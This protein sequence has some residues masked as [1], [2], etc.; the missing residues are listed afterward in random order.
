MQQ[1]R[2]CGFIIGKSVRHSSRVATALHFPF[3]SNFLF[4]KN[5]FSSL[6][7]YLQFVFRLNLIHLLTFSD[8]KMGLFMIYR[9]FRINDCQLTKM[10][11]CLLLFNNIYYSSLSLTSCFVTLTFY[12]LLIYSFSTLLYIEIQSTWLEEN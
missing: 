3:G 4:S 8:R 2:A 9:N 7:K 5:P 6:L 1:H 11:Q 12:L 10:R